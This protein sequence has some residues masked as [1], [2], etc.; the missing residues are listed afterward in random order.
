VVLLLLPGR[1]E[2]RREFELVLMGSWKKY[3]A[4][5]ASTGTEVCKLSATETDM[6]K[7]GAD[8]LHT[9]PHN[10]KETLNWKP[11]T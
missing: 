8:F 6:D 9:I 10:S 5:N 3:L 11:N 1:C 4:Q 7:Y 2:G